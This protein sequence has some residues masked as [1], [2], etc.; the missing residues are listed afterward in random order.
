MD[1]F[2][3]YVSSKYEPFEAVRVGKL[4][5]DFRVLHRQ[6]GEEISD[7]DTRF[8]KHHKEVVHAI[9]PLN[10]YQLANDS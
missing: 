2:M 1:R 7:F 3:E 8:E 10:K 4:C 9:G 6:P 5:D